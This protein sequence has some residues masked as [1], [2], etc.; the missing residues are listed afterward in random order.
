METARTMTDAAACFSSTSSQSCWRVLIGKT[1]LR[2]LKKEVIYY[3]VTPSRYF[4]SPQSLLSITGMKERNLDA[5]LVLSKGWI[6]QS[7]LL[8]RCVV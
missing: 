5:S 1:T 7:E 6:M 3:S 2:K 4:C 8:V